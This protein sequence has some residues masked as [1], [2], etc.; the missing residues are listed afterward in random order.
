MLLIHGYIKTRVRL[1]NILPNQWD[2]TPAEAWRWTWC[3]RTYDACSVCKQR[4]MIVAKVC[5][6]VANQ[7]A[8]WGPTNVYNTVASK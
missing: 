1:E 2:G 3:R 7:Q 5:L 6:Q 4:S 8:L